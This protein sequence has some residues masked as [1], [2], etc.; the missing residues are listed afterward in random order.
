[1]LS[2]EQ[3]PWLPPALIGKPIG[4][5]AEEI[6]GEWWYCRGR[7]YCYGNPPRKCGVE[8]TPAGLAALEAQNEQINEAI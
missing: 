1:M 3:G 4:I 6:C 2:K 8:L 5:K 7:H